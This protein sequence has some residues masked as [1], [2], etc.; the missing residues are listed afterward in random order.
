MKVGTF[1][2]FV[3]GQKIRRQDLVK[4]HQSVLY[5]GRFYTCDSRRAEVV[6]MDLA[7]RRMWVLGEEE[8]FHFGKPMS[9]A[10][11]SDGTKYVA[12]NV[13]KRIFVFDAG[14]RFVGAFGEDG[15]FGPTSVAVYG[16]S[17]FVADV[18]GHEVEILDRNTGQVMH[19][20]TG[21]EESATGT[22][23]MPANLAVDSRGMLYVADLLAANIHV[24]DRDLSFVRNIGRQGDQ[25][26]R[27]ARPRGIAVDRSGFVYVSDAAFE[28][29]Q[30]F[31]PEGELVLFFGGPGTDPGD[32]YLPSGVTISYDGLELFADRVDGRFDVSYL[33]IVANQYGP[34]GVS[35]YGFGTPRENA[36]AI[37]RQ[38][39]PRDEAGGS[40]G[41]KEDG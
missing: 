26:G 30:V 14:D 37:P 18:E 1:Q 20:L 16:D 38:T 5:R 34:N 15:Q 11:A 33:L 10:I 8:E 2:K 12:D 31:S 6:V 21:S 40:T 4:P 22:L 32:M 35:V 24:F 17:L 39:S 9:I 19:R 7:E 36:F 25:L 28:N 29:V 13:K 27:F 41:S 3:T 23:L